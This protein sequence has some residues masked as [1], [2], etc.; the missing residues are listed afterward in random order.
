MSKITDQV[1]AVFQVRFE[2]S[3][4]KPM[5]WRMIDAL[6]A[7]DEKEEESNCQLNP[8]EAEHTSNDASTAAPDGKK[9]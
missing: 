4:L 2:D 7:L 1:G 8:A 5:D 3:L 9:P 6:S